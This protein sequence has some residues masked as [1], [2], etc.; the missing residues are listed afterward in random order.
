MRYVK[1]NIE[2]PVYK[3]RKANPNVSIPTGGDL[4]A[5]GYTELVEVA[6]PAANEWSTVVRGDIVDSTMT[7][8]QQ[9]MS[10]PQIIAI[11]TK[12]VD[13]LLDIEA[14]SVNYDNIVSACSYAA[15]ANQFQ[16]E[17]QGFVVWRANVWSNLYAL[18]AEVQVGTRALPT[19][20]ELI[21]QL[22]SRL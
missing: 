5:L 3:I 20:A 22:P 13:D 7:W 15:V 10:V 2:V 12:E 19:L 1:D 8:V 6:E 16:A 18:M 14:Q 11:A 9:P 17:S 4:T 21:D